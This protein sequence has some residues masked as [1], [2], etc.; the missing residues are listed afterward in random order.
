M[1]NLDPRGREYFWLHEELHKSHDAVAPGV[2]TDYDA[3]KAGYVSISPLQL[4]RTAH[5]LIDK[6]SAWLDRE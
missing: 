3:I 6:M 2:L 1:E 5:L 4:D